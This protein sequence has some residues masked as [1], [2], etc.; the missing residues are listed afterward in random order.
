MNE[1]TNTLFTPISLACQNGS[2]ETIQM[3]LSH[4]A[5]FKL[6]DENGLNCLHI[7]SNFSQFTSVLLFV[8]VSSSPLACQNSHIHVVQWLVNISKLETENEL[9][10]FRLKNRMAMSMMLII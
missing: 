4:G 9:I 5:N 2:L 7:G 10:D 3:L 1:Q 8:V 6:R